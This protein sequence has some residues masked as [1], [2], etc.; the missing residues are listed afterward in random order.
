MVGSYGRGGWSGAGILAVLAVATA[1]LSASALAQNQGPA[2]NAIP[3]QVPITAFDARGKAYTTQGWSDAGSSVIVFDPND[4]GAPPAV[5]YAPPVSYPPT[6]SYPP[7]AVSQQAPAYPVAV[8]LHDP[9][10]VSDPYAYRRA[11][12]QP[13]TRNETQPV[14]PPAPAAPVVQTVQPAR[15]ALLHDPYVISDPYAYRRSVGSPPSYYGAPTVMA[16]VAGPAPVESDVEGPAMPAPRYIDGI[17]AVNTDYLLGYPKNLF[18]VLSAP[19][20]FDGEDWLTAGLVVAA[21]GAMLFLD[22]PIRDFWQDDV[23]NDDTDKAADYLRELGEFDYFLYGS[24]AAYAL[25]EVADT[26]GAI[27]ARR[28]KSAALLALQSTVLT[29]LLVNGVKYAVGRNRP[30]DAEDA[31]DFEGP[32]KGDFNAS[33]ISGHA[34]FAFSFATVL[35]EIYGPDNPWLPYLAYSAATG[36]ALSRINDDR[37]WLTDVAFGAA[38]G[39]A[40]AKVVTRYNPFLERNGIGLAPL[41]RDDARGVTV[42]LRF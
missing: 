24:L 32:S 36:T 10:V 11:I 31:F 9:Y 14:R 21:G 34:A 7:D 38:L 40:V 25:A 15:T 2:A 19:V 42:S 20:H 33:F 30:P 13:Q 41:Y 3:E 4:L 37:H 12:D 26:S 22:E 39:Y 23:R 6:A 29:G 5:S 35:S 1:G 8:P 28:E 16:E 17:Y 18:R 27:D